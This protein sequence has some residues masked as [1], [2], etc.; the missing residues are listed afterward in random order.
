MVDSDAFVADYLT[1]LQEVVDQPGL[2]DALDAAREEMR[3]I[4]RSGGKVMFAGNGAS[5]SIAS[6][7][8][9]DFTKQAGIPS[10]AFNDAALLTAYANDYGYERWV[11][12]AIRHHGRKEDL[13][14]L[15]S[16][17]GTSKNIVNAVRECREL[18]IPIVTFTGFDRDNPVFSVGQEQEYAF[19]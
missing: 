14:V 18:G 1:H 17:S 3:R 5:A 7:Y 4:G 16:T 12:Q 2:S 11:A 15:I 19:K 8:A 9:L 6:H 10:I 13:A